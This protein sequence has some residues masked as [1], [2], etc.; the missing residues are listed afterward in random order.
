[1][2]DDTNSIITIRQLEGSYTMAKGKKI[3]RQTT[4]NKVKIEK[5]EPS[6]ALGMNSRKVS[7]SYSI[8][9]AFRFEFMTLSV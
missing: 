5:H 4:V 7:S 8:N 3:K 1:M 2:F 9:G 6:Y